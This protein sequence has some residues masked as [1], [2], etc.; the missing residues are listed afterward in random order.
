MYNHQERETAKKKGTNVPDG[1][2]KNLALEEEEKA[3]LTNNSIS[4]DTIRSRVKRH[5]ITAYNPFEE[6][7]I[8][9]IEPILCDICI[10]LGKMGQPAL[11]TKST[12]IEFANSLIAKTEHQAKVETA[13]K[14]CRLEDEENLGTAWNRG[15]LACH[16]SPLTTSG[17]VIKDVKRRT[18]VTRENF[19]NMYEN[20]YK[21]MVEAGMEEELSK[22]IQH[23]AGLPTNYQLT[24]PK[25]VLFVDEI[26]CNT[27]QLNDGRVGGEL[28]ILPKI[29]SECGAPTGATTDLYYTVLPF[30]S[31]TGE[32]VMCAIIFKRDQDISE[33]PINWKTGIGITCNDIK[34]N[35]KVMRGGTTCYFQG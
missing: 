12:I 22:A 32:A 33:I 30:I 35:E 21:T 11:L 19:E 20:I 29:K 14:L 4:L 8:D 23:K 3:G 2:L 7:L 13:K 1:T 15:F 27:N 24:K 9:K 16:S 18:W 10:Q 31:G 34:D 25:Y 26:G 6:H 5:N 28:L 17:T